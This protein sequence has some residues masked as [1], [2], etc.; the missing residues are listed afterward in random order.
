MKTVWLV[1]ALTAFFMCMAFGAVDM[2]NAASVTLTWNP[3]TGAKSYVVYYGTSSGKYT[4][5]LPA[6][7]TQYTVINLTAGNTYYFAVSAKNTAGESK[8]SNEVSQH[9]LTPPQNLRRR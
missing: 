7:A 4:T 3:S 2:A 5:A 9:L 8:L 6:T 1:L